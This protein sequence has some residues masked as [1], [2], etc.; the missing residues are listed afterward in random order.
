MSAGVFVERDGKKPSYQY[1]NKAR[2]IAGFVFIFNKQ[3]KRYSWFTYLAV[4]YISNKAL[5]L[6]IL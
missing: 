3:Q 6:L 2:K 1:K 4:V 5:R